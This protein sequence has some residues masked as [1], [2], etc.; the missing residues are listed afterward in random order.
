MF[1]MLFLLLAALLV[2]ILGCS[3]NNPPESDA[4]Q[5]SK[6]W[7]IDQY[8]DFDS[9][10]LDMRTWLLD[11]R[12]FVGQDKAREIAANAPF[13]LA[14]KQ[15]STTAKSKGILLVHGLGDSPYSFVDIAPILAEQGFRVRVI[16]LPGHGTR[17]ADLLWATQ[18][19]WEDAV[20]NHTKLLKK[21]VD[22]VWLGGFSTGANLVTSLAIQDKSIKGLLLFSPAFEPNNNMLPFASI[23]ATFVDWVDIDPEVNMVRYDSLT[24][25]AASEYYKTSQKVQKQLELQ[26]FDRPALIYMSEGDSVIN[27]KHALETFESHF[28]HGASRFVWYGDKPEVNDSRVTVLS[29][30][31]PKEH[32]SNFSHMAPLFAP[33]NSYYGEHGEHRICN[34]G[35]ENK[36]TDC[37]KVSPLWF[38]S[39]GYHKEG[40]TYARLTWNPYFDHV[41]Q[42]VDRVMN[43]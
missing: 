25:N 13:Q 9:Y 39:Y 21:Q 3:G 34:N 2:S 31:L 5:A 23:A 30:S 32:I 36:T 33:N 17:P 26:G 24:T 1:K 35:E 11:H 14:P 40:R 18:K 15:G 20:A 7:P 27:A 38:S 16:L 10:V 4:Y 42:Q 8:H 37:N 22:E 12:H 41:A 19:D 43:R 6:R 28:S 29:A